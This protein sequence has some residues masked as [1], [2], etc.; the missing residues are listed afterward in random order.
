MDK[1]EYIMIGTKT[2]S[3]DIFRNILRPLDNQTFKPTGGLWA[4][5]YYPY[6][7]SSWF[8]YLRNNPDL[9]YY[10]NIY[11][12]SLFTLKDNA[13]ILLIDSKKVLQEIVIKYPSYSHLLNNNYISKDSINYEL[14]SRDYDG[15]Y[16][17]YNKLFICN[18]SPIIRAW[19][20]NTLLLFNLDVLDKYQSI[21]IDFHSPS[22][23]DYPYFK[24]IENKTIEEESIYHRELYNYIELVFNELIRQ[25]ASYSDYND[26]FSYLVESIKTSIKFA[27]KY[28]IDLAIKIK[29]HLQNQSINTTEY[30]IIRNIATN[31]LSNYFKNN[32][33]TEKNIPKT[34]IKKLSEYPIDEN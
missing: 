20:V 15:I 22:N 34:K 23:F 5:D 4:S 30:I 7:I 32:V 14:L 33:E 2:L 9:L 27:L 1:K 31:V 24:E 17:D 16:L 29:K 12:A 18:Y 21:S 13:N 26:Y 28:K 11:A 8:D 10:K 6:I 3:K 19:N 25:K